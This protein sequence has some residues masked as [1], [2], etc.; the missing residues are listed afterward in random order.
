LQGVKLYIK[1]LSFPENNYKLG[2]FMAFEL[3]AEVSHSADLIEIISLAF[4]PTTTREKF[5]YSFR[6]FLQ[7]DHQRSESQKI[8]D[9]IFSLA[10]AKRFS[11]HSHGNEKNLYLQKFGTSQINLFNLLA[12]KVPQVALTTKIANG[13]IAAELPK[14]VIDFGIG[15]G[16]QFISL[17]AQLSGKVSTLTIVGIEPDATSLSIAQRDLVA[18]GQDN[19]IAVT[20][21]SICSK[22]E[23]LTEAHWATLQQIDPRPVVNASFALHHILESPDL[24]RTTILRRI[25]TLNPAIVVL[26]EPDVDHYT[27]THEE[28]VH[29]CLAHFS[30]TFSSLDAISTMSR[31]EKNALKV[32]FFGREI[33]DIIGNDEA[34]RVERHETT[35]AWWQRLAAAGFEQPGQ[36]IPLETE[37]FFNPIIQVVPMLGS[38]SLRHKGEPLVSVIF[39][40]P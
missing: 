39:A 29:N 21:I 18:A 10:L 3:S 31:E 26:S 11:P 4:A 36:P 25:R 24:T 13:L 17:L 33:E 6:A 9:T 8:I 7:E 40:K 19:G 30:A 16:R 35:E 38:Y 23:D 27:S 34:S 32:Q 1:F 5:D 22:V 12:T 2:C 15:T 20:F 28:R 14:C 37:T